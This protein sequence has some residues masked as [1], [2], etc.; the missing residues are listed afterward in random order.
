MQLALGHDHR[1]H[2]QGVRDQRE[3]HQGHGHPARTLPES[4]RRDARRDRPS[5]QKLERGHGAKLRPARGLL[6]TNQPGIES[7]VGKELAHDRDRHADRD[8]AVVARAEQRR[9]HED[10]QE[11]DRPHEHRAEAHGHQAARGLVAE[12]GGGAVSLI[13]AFALRLAHGYLFASE[14][15]RHDADHPSIKRGQGLA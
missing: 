4:N 11:A 12:M 5:D 14:P 2:S 1:G 13:G 15:D 10:P 8:D 9:K 6:A 7:A 3:C